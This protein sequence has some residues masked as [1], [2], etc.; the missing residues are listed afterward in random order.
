MKKS[1]LLNAFLSFIILSMISCSL[2]R[3]NPLDPQANEGV[4][5]PPR[6]DSLWVYYGNYILTWQ[7]PS[8]AV[9]DSIVYADGYYV[10][11]ARE[12]NTK[13]DLLDIKPGANDTTYDVENDHIENNYLVFKVSSYLVYAPDTLQ[14][15]FSRA[16]TF[17]Q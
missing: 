9:D 15:Y 13:F 16:V 3:N 12:W 8:M 6:V 17:H 7:K 11:G 1:L 5:N 2:D 4:Y 10:W 14:G